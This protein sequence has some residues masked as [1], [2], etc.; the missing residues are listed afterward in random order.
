[1]QKQLKERMERTVNVFLITLGDYSGRRGLER[2]KESGLL[3]P[4]WCYPQ[5]MAQTRSTAGRRRGWA[6]ILLM[7][8]A[9]SSATER[10]APPPHPQLQQAADAAAAGRWAEAFAAWVELLQQPPPSGRTAAEARR[11]AE[12][13]AAQLEDQ[14]HRLSAADFEALRP[15][16]ST[17]AKER[18]HAA[19]MLL[20]HRLREAGE[21]AAAFEVL[22]SAAAQG[23]PPAMIQVGLMYSNGD[24]VEKDLERASYW[25]RPANVKGDPVGKYLLAECFL[26]GKGVAANHQ[27]AVTLLKE[28]VEMEDPARAMDLLGTCYHK[29]WGVERDAAAAARWY[30]AGCERGFD[31]A[32]ANLAVLHMRGE[33]VPRDPRRAWD[34][35]IVGARRGHPAS[36]FWCGLALESGAGVPPDPEMGRRW[37]VRAAQQGHPRAVAYCEARGITVPPPPEAPPPSPATPRRPDTPPGPPP[38]GGHTRRP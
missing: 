28:A 10:T 1:M 7:C 36:M 37:I 5:S 38:V 20:G 27:L 26:Y 8:A 11:Q 21:A 18:V 19:A 22:Q 15:A 12:R 33:G 14:P 29:G 25:L 35:W 24:G 13:L 32:C 6:L 2:K 16:L 30:Q 31:Q 34:L 23:H 9:V 4:I 17:L 3:R